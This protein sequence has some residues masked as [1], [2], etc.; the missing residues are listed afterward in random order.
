MADKEISDLSAATVLNDADLLVIEQ[1]GVTK[2]IAGSII[3]NANTVDGIHAG[4]SA[5][6]NILLALNA[7]SKLPASI[8]GDADTVDGKHASA[9]PAAA[10]IP[11]SGGDGKLAEGW[12]TTASLPATGAFS[13]H[14]NG[15]NQTG[16]VTETTTKVTFGTELFDVASWYVTSTDPTVTTGSRYTPQ[17]AGYYLIIAQVDWVTIENDADYSIGIIKNNVGAYGTEMV[18]HTVGGDTMI[19]TGIVQMNGSTDFLHID[20][21]HNAGVDQIIN[22]TSTQTFFTGVRIA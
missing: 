3:K 13:A 22:G 17:V 18:G 19:V 15:S 1:G 7:S 5:A 2:Q 8:T 12:I 9:T 16:I 14:K 4:T 11:V 10:T 20:C 21:W 6:A